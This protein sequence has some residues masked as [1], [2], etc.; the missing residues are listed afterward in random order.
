MF[1]SIA[2]NLP[3]TDAFVSAMKGNL[4]ND[5]KEIDS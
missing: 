4:T 2:N 3:T 1:T 5:N